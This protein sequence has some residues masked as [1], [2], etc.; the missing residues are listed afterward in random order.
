MF[1]DHIYAV[2]SHPNAMRW[3]YSDF[4]NRKFESVSCVAKRIQ[5]QKSSK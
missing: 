4:Q 5:A 3:L 2:D 1:D